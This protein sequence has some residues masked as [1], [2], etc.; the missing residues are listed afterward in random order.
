[1]F[2]FVSSRYLS[3]LE[4]QSGQCQILLKIIITLMGYLYNNSWFAQ[5]HSLSICCFLVPEA[6]QLHLIIFRRF[7]HSS[8][9][10]PMLQEKHYQTT[11]DVTAL[12]VKCRSSFQCLPVKIV[13]LIVL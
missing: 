10:F 6:F 9:Y 4:M 3:D 13:F 5:S 12:L 11:Y 7:N 2:F 1:M 8:G